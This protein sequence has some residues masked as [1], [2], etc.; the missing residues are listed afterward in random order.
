MEQSDS[1][2]LR[3]GYFMRWAVDQSRDSQV[4]LLCFG[5]SHYLKERLQRI[6]LSSI[7]DSVAL[8]PY[9]L[10]AII[11][12][13]LSIQ[14]DNTVWDLMSV[15]RQIESVFLIQVSSASQPVLI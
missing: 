14:M 12:E 10:F 8:D 13:E 2:W 5:A 11:A 7:P 6:P 3:S 4:T 1:T 9:S 15:F